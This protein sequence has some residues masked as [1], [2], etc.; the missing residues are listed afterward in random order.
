MHIRLF[1]N[2]FQPIAKALRCVSH[3]IVAAAVAL[4]LPA[5]LVP[6]AY[7]QCPCGHGGE[8]KLAINGEGTL[9]GY[10]GYIF[11]YDVLQLSNTQPPTVVAA[12]A[13]QSEAPV[14]SS[15]PIFTRMRGPDIWA[16]PSQVF[17]INW[18]NPGHSGS[19]A[20]NFATCGGK[21]ELSTMSAT[22]GFFELPGK[23]YLLPDIKQGTVWLRVKNE[24]GDSKPGDYKADISGG[25][26]EGAGI[27]THAAFNL[28]VNLGSVS[29]GESAGLTL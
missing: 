27:Q 16:F 29:D 17:K 10:Y 4:L 20:L 21:V 11:T 28:A 22:S 3:M 7:G 25:R 19:F 8:I 26:L 6:R 13:W 12:D 23:I 9:A 24:G 14:S 1:S 5:L 2:F 18:N 15:T